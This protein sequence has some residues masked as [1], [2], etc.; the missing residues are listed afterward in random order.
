MLTKTF[1]KTDELKQDTCT[2]ITAENQLK[3]PEITD[4]VKKRKETQLTNRTEMPRI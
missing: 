1:N 4:V 2:I 3:R